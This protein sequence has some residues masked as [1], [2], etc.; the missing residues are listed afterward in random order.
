MIEGWVRA[1]D[2]ERTVIREIVS[3]ILT[4]PHCIPENRINRLWLLLLFSFLPV[5]V[6]LTGWGQTDLYYALQ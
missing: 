5:S 4:V 3:A 1:I 2:A 6:L